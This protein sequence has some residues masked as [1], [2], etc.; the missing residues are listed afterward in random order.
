VI[1]METFGASA[2]AEVLTEKFGFM[3][4]EIAER[5]VDFLAG[6]LVPDKP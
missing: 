1:G 6:P 5:I 2:P 3:P 4:E